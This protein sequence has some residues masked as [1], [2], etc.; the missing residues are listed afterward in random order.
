MPN[1]PKIAILKFSF[2]AQKL[3][4]IFKPKVLEVNSSSNNK[5]NK[6]DTFNKTNLILN[7][8]WLDKKNYVITPPAPLLPSD[9]KTNEGVNYGFGLVFASLLLENNST[10]PLQIRLNY[11][12]IRVLFCPA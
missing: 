10:S 5:K 1:K 6:T 2:I 3:V 7:K 11:K 12:V 8:I 9:G 4:I